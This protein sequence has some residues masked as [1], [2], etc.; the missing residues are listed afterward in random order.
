MRVRVR[1]G[2]IIEKTHNIYMR[3]VM[4]FFILFPPST[5]SYMRVGVGEIIER[6]T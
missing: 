2:G 3:V 4:C 6:K 1:V 5:P